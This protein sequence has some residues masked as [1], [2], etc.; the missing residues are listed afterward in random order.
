MPTGDAGLRKTILGAAACL[1]IAWPAGSRAAPDPSWRISEA[2]GAVSLVEADGVRPAAAGTLVSAGARVT[3]GPDGRAVLRRG[4]QTVALSPLSQI[5]LSSGDDRQARAF[6]TEAGTSLFKIGKGD[7]RPF[8]VFTPHLVAT[9]RGIAFIITAGPLGDTV[10]ALDGPV[11]VSTH[12]GEASETIGPGSVA[13]LSAGD[14]HQLRI[15]GDRSKVIRARAAAHSLPRSGRP[16]SA[17]I[18]LLPL[19]PMGVLLADGAL[20]PTN[21]A[22]ALAG[23]PSPADALFAEIGGDRAAEIVDRQ[24]RPADPRREQP[25]DIGKPGKKDDVEAATGGQ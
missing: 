20:R 18:D 13:T 12:D 24:E 25:Q 10:Q 9:G 22:A 11:E 1:T 7:G 4:D 23:S 17:A 3:T 8:V 16:G 2:S 19:V 5:R 14:L 21:V 15:E 6:L